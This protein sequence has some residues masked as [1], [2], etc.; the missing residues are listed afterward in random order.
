MQARDGSAIGMADVD[1]ALRAAVRRVPVLDVSRRPVRLLV[2]GLVRVLTRTPRSAAADGVAVADRRL[3][4]GRVRVYRPERPATDAALLWVHGGGLVIG[5]ARQDDRLCAG[6]AAE[7]GMTVVS[8]EYRLAPEHRF[9]AALEDVLS[10]WTG[11]QHEA[12]ALGVDPSRIVIG[13]ES[14]GGGL[15]AALAQR[16]R[17]LG[18]V[19]PIGQWLFCPMLDD[20]TAARR[21]L[22]ARKHLVWP[23]T[24]NRVGWSA[25][26]GREPGAASVPDYAVA[27]RRTDLAGL[28]PAWLCV[29][30]IE[31]FHD[32]VVAY[33][34]RLRDAG[35]PAALEV[36]P[37]APHGF[38]N[39]AATTP[40]AIRL[41]AVARA[42]LREAIAAG[43]TTSGPTA[44]GPT[45]SGPTASG[46]APG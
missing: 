17:D 38:E 18:G 2:R 40:P 34:A 22:D 35:V 36:V 25:Y 4:E 46:P 32:E 44:S 6:T 45:A 14:A 33:A 19:Q 42:W 43:A 12:A 24:S 1:P 16:L 20:R 10:A 30:D 27:A 21:E 26:L 39:W 7:L 28:P 23:N 29:S 15:A 13:G 3:G 9:P 5:A 41:L 31:L 37:G 8:A 11:L